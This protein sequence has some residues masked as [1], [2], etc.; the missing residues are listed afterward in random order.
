MPTIGKRIRKV[1]V[2]EGETITSFAKELNISQSMV[3]KICAD[4]AKPSDRTIADICRVF[5]INKEWLTTGKGTMLNVETRKDEI[6]E[7]LSKSTDVSLLETISSVLAD[8]PGA[9]MSIHRDYLIQLAEDYKER[10]SLTQ[11]E[12]ENR[13]FKRSFEFGYKLGQAQYILT[14]NLDDSNIV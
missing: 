11:E 9:L 13:I 8:V 7:I 4:K 3:S 1:I 12:W 10:D 2:H 5:N 6:K 14:N